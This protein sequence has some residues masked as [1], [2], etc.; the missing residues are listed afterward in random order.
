MIVNSAES[1]APAG[2]V[3]EAGTVAAPEFE[4]ASVTMAPAAGADGE[5]PVK[6]LGESVRTDK[7]LGFRVSSAVFL[8][9][10]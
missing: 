8:T 1:E 10:L 6:L 5:P 2:T 4:L 9:P 3:T 7:E